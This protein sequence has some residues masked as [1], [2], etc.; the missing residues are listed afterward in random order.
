MLVADF[1]SENWMGKFQSLCAADAELQAMTRSSEFRMLWRSDDRG[2][3]IAFTE[4]RLEWR[5]EEPVNEIW[6]FSLTASA[7]T[8]QSFLSADP[9]RHHHDLLAM[10]MRVEDFRIEGD[11]RLFMASARVVR[12]LGELARQLS[13]SPIA[14]RAAQPV[15]SAG[16]EPVEGRYL[17]LQLEGRRYRVYFERAGMGQPLLLLHTAGADSRQ[18]MH[19]LNDPDFTANWQLIAFDLPL[20]GRSMPPDQWW[21]DE[22]RL[23]TDFY[24]KFTAAFVRA[25]DLTDPIALGCSMG[26]EIVLELAYRYPD[27]F[28]AVIGCEAAE[29]IP[30]RKIAW[31]NHP[32]VNATE[33]V[34]S[35][36]DGLVGPG[37]P[38]RHRREIWWVYSQSGVG[39]FNG[40]I[41]F[42][43][44]EWDARDRVSKIDTGKCPVVIMT[45]DHDYSCTVEMSRATADRIPGARFRAMPGLGHFP[46]AEDPQLF[47]SYLL[48]ELQFLSG[49]GSAAR[50]QA[51]ARPEPR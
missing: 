44:G 45:G 34:P 7:A 39:V 17:W 15:A 33:A 51:S 4:D 38:E 16:I 50:G 8:W 30:G 36:I 18:Y 32:E 12:R 11:R 5:T 10:W 48:P 29:R 6:D 23:S 37:A 27:L 26:G 31:T 1:L 22:Y 28:A 21:L 47:K 14:R 46:I 40:D 13:A 9:P 35:W 20:H 41:E 2:V 43:S 49:S 24:A 25:L 42:F 3:V 19:M